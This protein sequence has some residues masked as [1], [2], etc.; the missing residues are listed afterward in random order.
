M[1]R[2]VSAFYCFCCS[3]LNFIISPWYNSDIKEA[4]RSCRQA[5]RKWRKTGLEIHKQ[6]LL[7]QITN[8]GKLCDQAKQRY[9]GDKIQEADQKSI[10]KLANV[11]FNKPNDLSLPLYDSSYE[12][13]TKFNEFFVKKIVTIHQN[14]QAVQVTLPVSSAPS[15]P[16]PIRDIPTPLHSFESST[17]E[18]IKKIIMESKTTQCAQDPIPTKFVKECVKVLLPVLTKIVNLSLEEGV[19]P[20]SL[21]KALVVPL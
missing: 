4:K 2:I 16:L 1:I 20:L 19:M 18:E 7:E 9:Y 11:L 13:A 10:Y 21:K 17:H 15:A 12:L 8:V 6:I 3:F 14:L 5:E